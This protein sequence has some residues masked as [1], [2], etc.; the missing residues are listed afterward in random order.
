[1]VPRKFYQQM[2]S[3][4]VIESEAGNRDI[5]RSIVKGAFGR[6]SQPAILPSSPLD[7]N[8]QGYVPREFGRLKYP[9]T[10]SRVTGH[11]RYNGEIV[12]PHLRS[13]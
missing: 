10:T 2:K 7:P 13:H 4:D 8:N 6:L 1:M 5:A 3:L 11:V 9:T 12:R